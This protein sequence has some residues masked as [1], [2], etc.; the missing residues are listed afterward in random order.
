MGYDEFLDR[1]IDKTVHNEDENRLFVP[2]PDAR[3]E[4]HVTIFV[5]FRALVTALNRGAEHLLK[6]LQ[7]ELGTSARPNDTMCARFTGEFRQERLAAAL[8]QYVDTYVICLA[9]GLPD[10]HFVEENSVLQCDA[11][12]TNADVITRTV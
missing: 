4:G 12:G 10:T 5:N 1:A 2:T 7:T 8:D 3:I 6:A 9:C 11:C